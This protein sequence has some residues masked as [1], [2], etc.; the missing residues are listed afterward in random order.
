VIGFLLS[1]IPLALIDAASALRIAVLGGMLALERS[2][3]L[4]GT[5]YVLGLF[6]VY[7]VIGLLFLL[8]L[9]GIIEKFGADAAGAALS[10]LMSPQRIDY[11]ISILIGVCLLLFARNVSRSKAEKPQGATPKEAVTPLKAFLIGFGTNAIINPGMLP[12]FAAFDQI[13]KSDLSKLGAILTLVYYIG[14]F[15]LPLVVLVWLRKFNQRK[16]ERV[17]SAITSFFTTR[18]KPMIA[19]LFGLLGIVMIF[20]GIGFVVFGITLIPTK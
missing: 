17:F 10:R 5:M 19:F 1:L 6:S 16:S 9:G 3:V 11:Y 18:G 7:L 2:P 13:M 20:D 14:V 12:S 8:G 15:V 4:C